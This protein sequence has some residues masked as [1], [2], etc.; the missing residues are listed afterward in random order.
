MENK[1]KITDLLQTIN[2][3][4]PNGCVF[5]VD[6]ESND[7][8]VSNYTNKNRITIFLNNIESVDLF[9]VLDEEL[10]DSFDEWSTIDYIEC[11]DIC[12]VYKFIEEQSEIF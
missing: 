3:K 1:L 8:L 7:A 4:A 11:T 6:I 10:D 9:T 2:S 12:E 5:S